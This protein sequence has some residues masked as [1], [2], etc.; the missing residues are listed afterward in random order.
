MISATPIIGIAGRAGSGKDTVANF[1]AKNFNGVV[2]AQAD[3]MKKFCGDVFGFTEQQ[4]WGPSE[5]RNAPVKFDQRGQCH[6]NFELRYKAFTLK[7]GMTH[8]GTQ[9]FDWFDKLSIIMGA[10]GELSPRVALQTLGTEWGRTGSKDMWNRHAIETCKSLLGGGYS[11]T[12]AGGLVQD[13]S[14]KYDYACISDVRFRNEALN[15]RYLGGTVLKLERKDISADIG[16]VKGHVSEAEMDGIPDH[17]YSHV[18]SNNW[19]LQDLYLE[20]RHSMQYAYGD[21]RG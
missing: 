7:M 4:L 14:A 1:I 19:T 12:R 20:L 21:A 6:E 10:T 13:A 15:I 5:F 11:Y 16:G 8:A 2:V 3:P 18:I 17:F 9:L